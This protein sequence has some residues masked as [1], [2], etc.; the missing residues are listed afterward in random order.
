MTQTSYGTIVG[1]Q[2]NSEFVAIQ[3]QII[4]VP[5]ELEWFKST[6]RLIEHPTGKI[7]YVLTWKKKKEK[8]ELS[9]H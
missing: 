5:L 9:F 2:V 7:V 3:I 6:V 4:N 1:L 8:K